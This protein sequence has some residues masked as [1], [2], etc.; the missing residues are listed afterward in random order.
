MI[1]DKTIQDKFTRAIEQIYNLF[2][3]NL[4]YLKLSIV[5]TNPQE[6]ND[7]SVLLHDKETICFNR[8]FLSNTNHPYKSDIRYLKSAIYY[9]LAHE[10]F[11]VK[12]AC[13]NA[14]LLVKYFTRYFRPKAYDLPQYGYE[15]SIN[16][17]EYRL[18]HFCKNFTYFMDAY[19]YCDNHL[20]DINYHDFIFILQTFC[21]NTNTYESFNVKDTSLI[22]SHI[23][24][25]DRWA[26]PDTDFGF[27]YNVQA[28]VVDF[29]N[30]T[31]SVLVEITVYLNRSTNKY[32]VVFDYHS[33]HLEFSEPL[34]V[35]TTPW[36]ISWTIQKLLTTFIEV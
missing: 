4:R 26:S 33:Q 13:T 23:D 27:Q 10:I 36:M 35:T 20:S 2:K 30:K 25:D 21:L 29:A 6:Q 17:E 12:D 9:Q 28:S 7:P 34:L 24:N 31:D 32:R 11:L 3:I 22:F 16:I 18:V 15:E 5:D 8:Q 19:E 1:K 14:G